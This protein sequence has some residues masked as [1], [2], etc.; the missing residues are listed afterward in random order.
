MILVEKLIKRLKD[1]EIPT[2]SMS[3]SQLKRTNEILKE[4]INEE[5]E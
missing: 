3:T 1:E 5:K 4:L 2:Y